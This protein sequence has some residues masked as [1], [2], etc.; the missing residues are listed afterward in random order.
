MEI[1]SQ[2]GVM[3][4][5]KLLLSLSLD[6]KWLNNSL[7]LLRSFLFFP[8]WIFFVAFFLIHFLFTTLSTSF[9]FSS[10]SW[11]SQVMCHQIMPFLM[12]FLDL[13]WFSKPSMVCFGF[14]LFCFVGFVGFSS[15]LKLMLPLTVSFFPE[16]PLYCL[17]CFYLCFL[18]LPL[19]LFQA[20]R[21]PVRALLSLALL[22]V[23]QFGRNTFIPLVA[24][25]LFTL[26][27]CF[28]CGFIIAIF[29]NLSSPVTVCPWF[30]KW[31]A[32]CVSCCRE[33]ILLIGS[34]RPKANG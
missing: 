16:S 13:I 26:F 23:L 18:T 20:W 33:E 17:D 14:T 24:I 29:T 7:E 10:S 25:S 15:H 11:T 1:A 27:H 6:R 3:S 31:R 28:A 8:V 4:C 21:A 12:T 9:F 5:C 34:C 30:K 22:P 32:G 2:G 19:M